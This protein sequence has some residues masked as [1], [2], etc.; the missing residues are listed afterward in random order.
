LILKKNTTRLSSTRTPLLAV[1][2]PTRKKMRMNKKKA[3]V[4]MTNEHPELF[5]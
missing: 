2:K 1:N 3:R 5:D 4:R